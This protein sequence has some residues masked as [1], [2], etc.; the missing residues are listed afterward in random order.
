MPLSIYKYFFEIVASLVLAIKNKS[1]NSRQLNSIA[2]EL[3]ML[4]KINGK[5]LRRG[6]VLG[7]DYKRPKITSKKRKKARTAKQKAATRKLVALNRRRNR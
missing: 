2:A 1:L 3:I 7:L 4:R 6:T 5:V